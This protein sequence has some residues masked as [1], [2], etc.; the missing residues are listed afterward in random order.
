MPPLAGWHVTAAA[1]LETKKRKA[2][3]AR[4]IT[5]AGRTLHTHFV[6][7]PCFYCYILLRVSPSPPAER[8]G[9]LVVTLSVEEKKKKYTYRVDKTIFSR[10]QILSRTSVSRLLCSA[11]LYDRR[12]PYREPRRQLMCVDGHL[13]NTHETNS[14]LGVFERKKEKLSSIVLVKSGFIESFGFQR[15][16]IFATL[17]Y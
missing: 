8:H 1:A 17:W 12:R 7:A 14:R 15:I 2:T 5:T 6:V 9:R 4:A 11:E 13:Q 10:F 3:R 16:C